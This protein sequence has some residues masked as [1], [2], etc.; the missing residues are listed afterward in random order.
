MRFIDV[1]LDG[2][3]VRAQLNDAGAPK[4]TEAVWAALPFE[5]TAV[6]AQLSGDMFRMLDH[7]PLP[8]D[9][10]VESRQT[11]QHP[12]SVIYLPLIKEIAFC[13]GLARFKGHTGPPYLT[14]MAEIEGD[15][16]SF[17]EKAR[18]LMRVGG[19]PIRFRRSEDQTTPF[20]YPVRK[21]RKI[22]IDF[23]G[24]VVQ[25]T[26]L[27]DLA[28]KTT[29]A[30][31]KKL[32][33]VGIAT[34]DNWGGSVTRVWPSAYGATLDLGVSAGENERRLL[35]P[36]YVYYDHTDQSLRIV[37]ADGYIGD[38]TGGRPVTPVAV[39]DSGL[40]GFRAVASRQ[41]TEGE[42]PIRISPA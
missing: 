7:A 2:T 38:E 30:L 35:W 11:Y 19:K 5:G 31:L 14:P 28:P 15:V 42:K 41:L 27:E 22:R 18:T 6:H 17:G 36:G 39:L 23:G 40:E 13:Y 25:A 33:L 24:A 9:L 32:P 8:D 12:G 4:T 21:G 10:E 26:L 20:R 3:V 16:A 34:N 1:D 29:A 37:Y